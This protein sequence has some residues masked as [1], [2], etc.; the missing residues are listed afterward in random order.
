M[1]T[2]FIIGNGKDYFVRKLMEFNSGVKS[3]EGIMVDIPEHVMMNSTKYAEILNSIPADKNVQVIKCYEKSTGS[4][5][6]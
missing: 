1:G 6:I 4:I 3:I 2:Y 5:K